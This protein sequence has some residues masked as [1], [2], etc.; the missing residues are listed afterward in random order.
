LHFLSVIIVLKDGRLE[1]EGT[2]DE[3]LECCEDMRRLW[4][5]YLSPDDVA[6]EPGS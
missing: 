1:A 5:D 2:L 6:P 3:L 4:H